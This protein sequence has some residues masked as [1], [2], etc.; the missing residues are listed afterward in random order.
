[1]KK[2]FFSTVVAVFFFGVLS[3]V[4]ADSKADEIMNK[5]QKQVLAPMSLSCIK[6]DVFDQDERFDHRVMFKRAYYYGP[7]VDGKQERLLI[8]IVYPPN[9]FKNKYFLSEDEH[10]IKKQEIYWMKSLKRDRRI[11]TSGEDTLETSSYFYHDLMDHTW[12]NRKYKL[13]KQ[14]GKLF[15]IEGLLESD[16]V[17]GRILF[18]IEEITQN[19]FVYRTIDFFDRN[20]GGLW[21]R[22][23]YSQFKQIWDIYYRPTQII[24]ENL[25]NKKEKTV[26]SIESWDIRPIKDGDLL[27]FD[28]T[29][30]KKEQTLPVECSEST[31]R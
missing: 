10:D 24:M 16:P 28:S 25:K 26:L 13:V 20:T 22:E 15:T 7:T 11:N 27:F 31:F 6:M 9:K 14:Q 18:Q 17:Y 4:Y 1:M 8:D 19:N 29:T 23:T 21:K 30:F 3:S 12:D 2:L 5:V